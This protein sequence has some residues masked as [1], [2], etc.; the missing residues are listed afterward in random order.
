MLFRKISVLLVLVLLLVGCA[1]T[2]GVPGFIEPPRVSVQDVGLRH[3]SLTEGTAVIRLNVNNPNAFAVPLRGVEYGLA[4]NGRQVA[5]G[6][7]EQMRTINPSETALLEIPVQVRFDD[8]VGLF[9]GLLSEGRLQYDL[10][11]AVALPML[12]VPFSHRGGV[13]RLQ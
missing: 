13:G 9:S 7:Q 2:P 11:G 5:R 12:K 4:L 1:S 8:M 6:Q 3:V 10:Q